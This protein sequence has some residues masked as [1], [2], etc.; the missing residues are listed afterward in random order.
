MMLYAH[1]GFIYRNVT[2]GQTWSEGKEGYGRIL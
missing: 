2:F 1:A